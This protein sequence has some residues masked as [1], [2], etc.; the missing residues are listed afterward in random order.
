VLIHAG[1]AQLESWDAVTPSLLEAGHRVVRPDMRGWVESTTD[2]VEFD[3]RA[4]TVA[5]L[6]EL[7][8][9]AAVFV[10]NSM[11]G[12]LA[13]DLAIEHPSRV[14]GVVAVAAGLSG[15]DG[16]ATADE[17]AIF[18]EFER[19]ESANPPDADAIAELDARVWV[20]GPAQPEGRAPQWIRDAIV[21]WDRAINQPGHVMGR[22]MRLDPPAAQRLPELSCSV[23]AVAGTLDFTEVV[24]TARHL[25]RAAPNARAI[26][27]DDVA[28]MIG[29]EQPDRLAD[30]I[31]AF[32][33]QLF[34]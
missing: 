16:D 29:M 17:S 30:M 1:I 18:E 33:G 22:R 2:D 19:L 32:A 5:L 26:I 11:G 12:V 15:F 9:E 13:L 3:P 10:G 7:G 24:Q 20:D 4:D 23:L 14:V 8:I 31:V 6:D 25:E 28:H 34:D 27:W 21:E